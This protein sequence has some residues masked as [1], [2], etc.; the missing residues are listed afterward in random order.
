MKNALQPASS[1]QKRLP[2]PA[3]PGAASK[4]SVVKPAKPQLSRVKSDT[5]VLPSK[6][7]HNI[8]AN[9]SSTALTKPKTTSSGKVIPD[10]RSLPQNK[11][12][13]S[14]TSTTITA[15]GGSGYKGPIPLKDNKSGSK[16]F[17]PNGGYQGP[18]NLSG[19]TGTNNNKTS[20]SAKPVSSNS[21][22]KV[23]T[24]QGKTGDGGY[25]GPLKLGSLA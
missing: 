20:S 4:K 23:G 25:K 12:K 13:T 8:S 2:D 7:G 24:G 19:I 18:L 14:S 10:K 22:M 9:K 15:T 17:K 11:P 3:K 21:G 6:R 16:D 5:A 1:A